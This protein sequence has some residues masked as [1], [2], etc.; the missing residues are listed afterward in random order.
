MLYSMKSPIAKGDLLVVAGRGKGQRR[1]VAEN[2]TVILFSTVYLISNL[3]CGCW[4]R[5]QNLRA[6]VVGWLAQL[7]ISDFER[8]PRRRARRRKGYALWVAH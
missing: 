7:G 6:S 1:P 2:S 3:D 4:A 5:L 8:R